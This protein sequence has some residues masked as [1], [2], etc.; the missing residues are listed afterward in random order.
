[1]PC[2]YGLSDTVSLPFLEHK[3]L[4]TKFPIP[5]R[6]CFLKSVLPSPTLS[7]AWPGSRVNTQI[8][9]IHGHARLPPPCPLFFF[10]ISRQFFLHISSQD[11]LHSHGFYFTDFTNL[12]PLADLDFSNKSQVLCFYLATSLSWDSECR[13]E[14]L[15]E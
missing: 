1:M 2:C 5:S 7:R 11:T 4:S 12:N 13:M 14:Y 8:F 15:L 6:S 10:P 9:R 3:N